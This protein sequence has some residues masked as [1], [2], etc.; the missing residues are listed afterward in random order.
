MS[1]P[2]IIQGGMGAG[3]SGWRLAR[4]VSQR[5]QLGVVAGT[6][7]DSILSRRLQRGDL[8]GHLRRAMR[9][10]PAPR[11]A[12]RVL[13]QF[14]V[15]G[16]RPPGAPFKP[17]PMYSM[18]P[19]RALIELAVLAN[20]VE[21]YLAKEGHDGVVGINYLDKIQ[22][23]TLPSLFGA[24]LAG[25]DYVIVGAGV[26]RHIPGILD[27]LANCDPVEMK[28]DV[29]GAL[30]NEE[31]TVSFDPREV[32]PEIAPPLGRPKFLAIIA[33]ATLAIALV[34]KGSG[35][36]DG[37]IVEGPTA[38]GHNAPPRGPL[39]LNDRGEP[40]YGDRDV[41]ELDKLRALGLPFWLAG[42]YGEPGRLQEA[43]ASGAAGVQ[44]GTAFA[45]CEESEVAPDIKQQVLRKSVAGQVDV[46]SDPLASPTGFPF[47]ILHVE[48][49]V[50]DP[51]YYAQRERVCDLG[52][53]RHC[54]RKGDGTVGY[55]CPAE[56][57]DLYLRKGGEED[58]TV[59]RKCI[60]NGLVATIGLSQVRQGGAYEEPVVT[61]GDFAQ[62]VGRF[63]APGRSSYTASEVIDALL[64]G[65]AG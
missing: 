17:I 27:R 14:F 37:F 31:F 52:Y 26:P 29:E 11:V 57:I 32:F 55:R 47:K 50:S 41:V 1:H 28:I 42:S 61:A 9:A 59:G 15:E 60:C 24:M 51:D 7:L 53:L 6:A 38:G 25:V 63:L 18:Q 56:P 13:D 45:F 65:L 43:I 8:E 35:R 20:F 12:Q 54:Y 48:G 46:L 10:F 30:P 19:N 22:F 64:G 2:L 44:V 21:I 3:V 16:G 5:G 58:D 39:Q 40:V 33:A 62:Q 4:A 36:V 34:R 23:P 49:S